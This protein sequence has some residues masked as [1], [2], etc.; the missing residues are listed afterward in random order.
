MKPRLFFVCLSTRLIQVLPLLIMP[1]SPYTHR[2]LPA[3]TESG[4]PVHQPEAPHPGTP[5]TQCPSIQ[6]APGEKSR[7]GDSMPLD[8]PL[9]PS[10]LDSRCM[11]FESAHS[12]LNLPIQ[13]SP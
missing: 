7:S 8:R 13:F 10:H 11:E 5:S 2:S 12:F 3:H 6:D 1:R 9:V 4:D